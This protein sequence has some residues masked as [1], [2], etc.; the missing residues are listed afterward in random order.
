MTASVAGRH[1][2]PGSR[3]IRLAVAYLER[4]LVRAGNMRNSLATPPES[5][6]CTR[7][8]ADSSSRRR[9]LTGVEGPAC[10]PGLAQVLLCPA[11]QNLSGNSRHRITRGRE[12]SQSP[13]AIALKPFARSMTPAGSWR[14]TS[15]K[16][17]HSALGPVCGACTSQRASQAG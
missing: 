7:A 12:G 11:R 5:S 17:N 9:R 14:S 8:P 3:N 4:S 15:R 13:E 1:A 16:R 10:W 6:L 2:E